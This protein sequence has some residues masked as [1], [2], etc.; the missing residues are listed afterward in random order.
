MSKNFQLRPFQEKVFECLMNGHSVILQA[1]T[2]SG[3][4]KA[5]LMPFLQNL[6][7]GGNTL[8]H[9]CRY[10]VPLKVLANQF[11]REFNSIASRIDLQGH[12]HLVETYQSLNSNAISIQTGEQP[13][14]PQ[15]ESALTFCTI[16]QLLASF[17]AVPYGVG[18]NRANLNVG[19]VIGSFLILDEF[20]LYP[21]LRE[22]KSASEHA[23]LLLRCCD[24]SNQLRLLYS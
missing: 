5:A 15:M 10:A 13:D 9:T 17:L 1:P 6:A 21:L 14:D 16:D 24:C 19:G 20:H 12:T 3:K 2:G 7:Q 23:L 4:T 11:Y 22:G 18:S 8:P